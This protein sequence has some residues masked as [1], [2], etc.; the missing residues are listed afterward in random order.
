MVIYCR[1][2]SKRRKKYINGPIYFIR[3]ETYDR[4]INDKWVMDPE[5]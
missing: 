2:E 3:P 4:E 5:A 1:N